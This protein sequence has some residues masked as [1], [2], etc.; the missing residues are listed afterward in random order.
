M[1][2]TLHF[3]CQ[4]TSAGAGKTTLLN[5]ILTEQHQKKIA[6]ILNEFGEG[7]LT[8]HAGIILS[9]RALQMVNAW[10]IHAYYCYSAGNV[11][12][13]VINTYVDRE[14]TQLISYMNILHYSKDANLHAAVHYTSPME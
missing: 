2:S 14:I 1:S 11:T 9:C 12:S 3:E 4:L 5:Y 13:V 10:S 8:R 7:K 6:V